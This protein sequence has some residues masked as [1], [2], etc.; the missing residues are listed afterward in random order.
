MS[1]DARW[2]P[3]GSVSPR[4]PAS[5]VCAGTTLFVGGLGI[6]LS[7]SP[8]RLLGGVAERDDL[9]SRINSALTRPRTTAEAAFKAAMIAS[10]AR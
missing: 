1:A 2:A 9:L 4:R 10:Y 5:A 7:S 6:A 8:L 3:A